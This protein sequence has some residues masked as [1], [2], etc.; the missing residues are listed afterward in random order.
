M[1][2]PRFA[3]IM[4]ASTP[5]CSASTLYM[6]GTLHDTVGPT[7]SV[8]RGSFFIFLSGTTLTYSVSTQVLPLEDF[9]LGVAGLSLTSGASPIP[10]PL[11]NHG[12]Y[13]FSGCSLSFAAYPPY[14]QRFPNSGIYFFPLGIGETGPC[15]SVLQISMLDGS[16]EIP[17]AQLS[18]F[19]RPDFVV[20]F[21][22]LGLSGQTDPNVVI[23][24]EPSVLALLAMIAFQICHRRRRA[25]ANKS[26]ERML[27][28]A[29]GPSRHPSPFSL[30]SAATAPS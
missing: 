20:S 18:L 16:V 9:G 5:L 1:K 28:N 2:L 29:L 24:P 14:S 3:L 4:I 25:E 7:M 10:L 6:T 13:G 11:I 26:W 22:S 30:Y 17:Q 21:N 23:I 8:A 27:W 12:V 15:D 19:D